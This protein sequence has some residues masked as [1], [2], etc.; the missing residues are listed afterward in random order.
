MENIL[1]HEKYEFILP[2]ITNIMIKYLKF[3]K[4]K[5]IHAHKNQLVLTKL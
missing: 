5:V 1:K 2:Q 4:F 3:L